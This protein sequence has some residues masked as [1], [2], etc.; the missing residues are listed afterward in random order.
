[1]VRL[2]S[3]GRNALAYAYVPLFIS[4]LCFGVDHLMIGDSFEEKKIEVILSNWI[5]FCVA[6]LY[7]LVF[8]SIYDKFIRKHMLALKTYGRMSL[9]N[10]M[11]QSIIGGLLFA[12]FGFY[13]ASKLSSSYLVIVFLI[14]VFCQILFSRL[15]LGRYRYGPFESFWRR[16]S[17][18]ISG[19]KSNRNY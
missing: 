4:I 5:N 19:L 9:T 13:L 6:T 12:P 10:Y 15:W 7:I 11:I 1:M 16:S 3:E 17:L 2:V 14:F 18:I 8:I